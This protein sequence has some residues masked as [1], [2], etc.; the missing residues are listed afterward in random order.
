MTQQRTSRK[1]TSARWGLLL[2][3]FLGM[4]LQLS[5]CC[6]CAEFADDDSAEDIKQVDLSQVET[7]G[8][9]TLNV[10]AVTLMLL[11]Q[12]SDAYSAEDIKTVNLSQVGDCAGCGM[13]N[14]QLLLGG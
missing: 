4:M 2:G 13:P 8:C 6:Y 14:L 12:I 11:C 3:V 5:H 10:R 9:V 7:A 1:W